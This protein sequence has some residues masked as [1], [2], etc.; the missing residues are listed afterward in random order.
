MNPGRLDTQVSLR[1]PSQSLSGLRDPHASESFSELTT[2]KAEVKHLRG[3]ELERAQALNEEVQTRITVRH[4][5][6]T[7]QVRSSWRAHH[8]SDVYHILYVIPVPGG[9]RSERVELYC[10]KNG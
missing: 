4:D 9:A 1:Q 10:R 8:G 3:S 6:Q 7:S 2:R 5:S